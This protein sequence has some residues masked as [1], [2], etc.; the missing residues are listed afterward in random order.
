MFVIPA[1]GI[2]YFNFAGEDLYYLK[3][4][5]VH[6]FDILTKESYSFPVPPGF[7]FAVATDERLILLK[8]GLAEVFEFSPKK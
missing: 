1:E 5:T 3:G 6:F 4:E 2:H 8:D 7:Q